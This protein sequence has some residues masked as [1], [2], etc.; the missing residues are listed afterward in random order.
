V[1]EAVAAKERHD[2]TV[3]RRKRGFRDWT[4]GDFGAVWC[5]SDYMRPQ[6][7][8][9]AYYKNGIRPFVR[10]FRDV[11]LRDVTW[12]LARLWVYGGVAR[13]DLAE[14]VSRWKGVEETELGLMVPSHER[15]LKP[16]K[17]MFRDAARSGLLDGV[18]PFASLAVRQGRGRKD[19]DPPSVATVQEL[20]RAAREQYPELPD[21][22]VMIQVAAYSGLRL[23]EL[24]G[25]R[26]EDLDFERSTLRVAR[27]Y[28][29]RAEE[30]SRDALPKNGRTRRIVLTPP[31]ADALRQM[32]RSID[33]IVFHTQTGR[34]LS[35]RMWQ[36]YWYPVRGAVP[37]ARRM[38]F[39]MLR[40]FYGTYLADKGMVGRDIAHQL[41]HTDG[42]RLADELYCHTIPEN[43]NARVS[44]IFG[45]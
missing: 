24:A 17:A 23:G 8:S 29:G 35:Q 45:M 26:W 7:T 19:V 20:V 12:D 42:G 2:R 16:A 28:R 37:A 4:V 9:N 15:N 25:L 30:G 38:P 36:W 13:P 32:P 33:G 6:V 44:A 27:Q 21:I 11:L 1:D 41:G 10:D 3:A 31:A 5:V 22:W 39:H 18:S 34:H 14:V 43:S 40:H